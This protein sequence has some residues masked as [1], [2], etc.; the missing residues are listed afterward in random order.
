MA[1]SDRWNIEWYTKSGIEDLDSRSRA[2]WLRPKPKGFAAVTWRLWTTPLVEEKMGSCQRVPHFLFYI[3]FWSLFISLSFSLLCYELVVLGQRFYI[4]LVKQARRVVLG[5]IRDPRLE[6][7]IE[8]G[9]G[10]FFGLRLSLCFGFV[11]FG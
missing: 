4:W 6:I 11:V 9:Y 5:L 2:W 10:E 1:S 8:F 3:C 7:E